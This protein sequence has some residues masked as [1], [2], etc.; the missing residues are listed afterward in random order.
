MG[1]VDDLITSVLLRSILRLFKLTKDCLS[2]PYRPW[3]V[4]NLETELLHADEDGF[5]IM[6]TFSS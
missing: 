2:S 3:W 1:M 6:K 4:M 5:V